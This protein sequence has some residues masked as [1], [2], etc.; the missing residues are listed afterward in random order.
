MPYLHDG[1]IDGF[2][3]VIQ[4]KNAFFHKIE[5]YT[6]HQTTARKIIIN[7][8]FYDRLNNDKK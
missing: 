6:I 4:L 2:R 5:K 1:S 8:P 7:M 3:G